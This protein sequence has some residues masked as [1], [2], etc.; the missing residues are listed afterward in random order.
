MGSLGQQLRGEVKL[1]YDVT[2]FV[3]ILDV[4]MASLVTPA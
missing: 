2:G 1:A 4:P 3:Y